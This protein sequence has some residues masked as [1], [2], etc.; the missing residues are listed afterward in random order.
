M[1]KLAPSG[2]ELARN[3]TEGERV[4][5]LP[6]KDLRYVGSFHRKRS[7]SLPEGGSLIVTYI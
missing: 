7:P 5:I 3:A 2:R 6:T 1:R 4:T